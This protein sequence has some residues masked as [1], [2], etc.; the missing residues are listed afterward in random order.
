M[1]GVKV[2]VWSKLS[3]ILPVDLRRSIEANDIVN[4]KP[5]L[6]VQREMDK[7]RRR[8]SQHLRSRRA[9]SKKLEKMRKDEKST[10]SV[11]RKERRLERKRNTEKR[12]RQKAA[13]ATKGLPHALVPTNIPDKHGV[14][15][16]CWNVSNDVR[17]YVR[18]HL[19]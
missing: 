6:N 5:L 1:P 2:K 18:V 4:A 19:R 16:T 11:V 9:H 8:W 12:K 7:Q 10:L 14:D 15:P 3:R 17:V 13:E